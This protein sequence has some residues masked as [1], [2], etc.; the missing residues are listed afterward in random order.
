MLSPKF[1]KLRMHGFTL[2]ETTIAVGILGIFLAI[3]I[4]G[5][6]NILNLLRTSKDNVSA[7]QTLQ[8]RCEQLRLFT[9]GQV[10]NAQTIKDSILFAPTPSAAGLS[11]TVETVE[12]APYPP[13]PLFVPVKVVRNTSGATV[14]TANAL[15]EK[16][17]MIRIDVTVSWSGFPRMRNRT[18]TT[19]MLV[20][21][22]GS[23]K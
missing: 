21:K 22:P 19:S 8:Q 9:W 12:V 14:V 7:S 16:E 5:S 1:R 6:S 23:A 11:E 15:L 10:T 20:S 2:L 4:T 13:K 3:L 18:R 17:S